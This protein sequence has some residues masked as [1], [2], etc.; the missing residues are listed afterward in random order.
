MCAPAVPII[1]KEFSSDS[2]AH[3]TLIVSI[4]ELGEVIGP[5]VIAPLAELYGRKPVYNSAAVLFCILSVA[6][7]LS[8]N[9]SM[10]LAFRF[11]IGMTP[12][13]ATLN[14]PIVADMFTKE[15]RGKAISM[16]QLPALLGTVL[17]PTIGSYLTARM[18]WRWTFWL[19]AI[20]CGT[21][22]IVF[23][24][25]YRETYRVLILQKR[26]EV[27]QKTTGN[28][29]LRSKYDSGLTKAQVFRK[30]ML[31]PLYILATSPIVQLMGLYVAL[32]YGYL[33]T[34]LTT[35]GEVFQGY[36]DFPESSLGLVYIGLGKS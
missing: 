5:L 35:I 32:V 25:V 11:L 19:A 7:A 2:Q 12:P 8:T 1:L 21:F 30:A 16:V 36:Y 20:I 27:L 13:T 6:C 14:S 26:V 3:Q 18:G 9:L 29:R 33:F 17:G 34:I 31:R 22:S 23:A 10:L 28:Y 4:W 24:F 15:Q